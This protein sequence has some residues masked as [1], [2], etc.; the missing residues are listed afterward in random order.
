MIA[1]PPSSAET[2]R[3]AVIAAEDLSPAVVAF[4]VV[5][6]VASL[7]LLFV[8]LRRAREA[9]RALVLGTGALASLAVLLAI[10]RP[11][12]LRARELSVAPRV[13]VLLDRS[14]SMALPAG[15]DPKGQTRIEVAEAAIA[16]L[17]KR[18]LGRVD[19]LALGP[20]G[21]VRA[22][23]PAGTPVRARADGAA[24]DLA[25][26]FRAL[27]A[28]HDD[29]PSAIV[30]VSDGRLEIGDLAERRVGPAVHAVAIGGDA[31]PD[32]AIRSVRLAGAAVAHQ[33]LPIRIEVAC[34]GGLACGDLPVTVRE[35]REGE[36]GASAILATGTA[37]PKDGAATIEL[38]ITLERAG[39]RAIEVSLAAP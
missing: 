31:P 11:Q 36:G 1:E 25:S 12:R 16:E 10:V 37:T 4:A 5:V 15:A 2:L 9:R 8:E 18:N 17:R 23:A 28:R 29:P 30:V 32:A 14:R 6:T 24:R 20:S 3:T 21:G 39:T 33:A 27:E 34:T 38:P 13:V 7:V 35:L 22:A 26:A 19:V